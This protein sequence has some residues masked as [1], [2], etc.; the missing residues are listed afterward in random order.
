MKIRKLQLNRKT[1]LAIT[2]IAIAALLILLGNVEA[3]KQMFCM[4][5]SVYCLKQ[6]W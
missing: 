6:G 5:N 1:V 3:F 4:A 2:I